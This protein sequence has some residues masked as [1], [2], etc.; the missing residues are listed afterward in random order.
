VTRPSLPTERFSD[1]VADYV[2]A[3]PGYPEGVLT[4][5]ARA[6]DRPAPW[7]IADLGSGTGL[8]AELFLRHGHVV[9]AVEPNAA[10]RAAAE[11]RLGG[12]A[13]FHSVA[14][15]AEETGLPGGRCDLVVA[16]QAFHWFDRAAL[17]REVRRILAPGGWLLVMWNTRRTS[18]SPFLVAYEALLQ[19]FGTDYR[20]VHH[21]TLD[22]PALAA[23]F[24]ADTFVR[25]DLLNLQ[26]LDRD[27]LRARLLS[28]SYVPSRED[29]S[30]RPMLEA[31]DDLFHA[32]A[33][34]GR[35]EMVYDTEIYL[36]QPSGD[37]SGAAGPPRA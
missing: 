17:L 7:T 21:G 6:L 2:R 33:V 10:M 13:S 23:L 5:V 3:R 14:G 16:A 12:Q 29:P 27:A 30:H 36:G 35:V 26:S 28:S 8:S 1:R 20:T 32:H 22:K 25:A 31:L 24:T 9:H 18:G 4:L 34:A 37:P 19:R 11:D 15:R